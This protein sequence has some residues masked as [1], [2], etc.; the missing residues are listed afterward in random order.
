[1][2]TNH[3]LT[4]YTLFNTDYILK[5]KSAPQGLR[6]ELQQRALESTFPISFTFNSY[7]QYIKH[8]EILLQRPAS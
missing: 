5:D 2:V 3:F 8:L 6:D 1:M 4:D 7:N